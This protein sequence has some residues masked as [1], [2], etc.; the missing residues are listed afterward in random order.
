MKKQTLFCMLFVLCFIPVLAQEFEENVKELENYS[1]LPIVP[2]LSTELLITGGSPENVALRNMLLTKPENPTILKGKKIAVLSTDGVEE[3]ELIGPIQYLKK[4]G[5][6]V[7][8]VAP[9]FQT[10]PRKYGV[11]YPQQRATHIL[12]IRYMENASWIPIDKFIDDVTVDD[13]DGL[14]IPGGAWN[15]DSLR[16]DPKVQ[17]FVREMYSQ[18][19]LTAAICHGPLVF[20]NAGIIRG[21]KAT[22]FWN[23]QID[24]QNAGANVM[25][26]AVVVDENMVTS[27]YPFDLP[28]FM[29]AIEEKILK[30]GDKK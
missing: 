17:K 11:V 13:Y 12:T 24:I 4:R 6:E 10:L 27:R 18:N 8:L 2:R 29:K 23:V 20:V 26:Q 28:D 16:H 22:C 5:A 15:P 21:K 9:R 19:K 14:I 7:H 30:Q 3:I 1:G 25:D